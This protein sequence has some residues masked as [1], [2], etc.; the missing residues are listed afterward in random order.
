MCM[1]RAEHLR[2]QQLALSIK[3]TLNIW[4]RERDK[5]NILGTFRRMPFASVCL[6]R[7]FPGSVASWVAFVFA[8]AGVRKQMDSLCSML[9]HDGTAAFET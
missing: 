1:G 6:I 5:L 9:V 4:E 8:S 3:S 7:V 2:R